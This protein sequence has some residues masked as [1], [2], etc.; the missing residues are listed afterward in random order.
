MRHLSLILASCLLALAF[1]GPSEAKK[2]KKQPIDPAQYVGQSTTDAMA[3]LVA[4]AR[5]SVKEDTWETIAIARVLLLGGQEAEGTK[6]LDAVADKGDASDLVRVGRVYQ[7]A[8]DWPAAKK[9][10]DR[11]VELEPKD[12]DWLAE[13]G[14]YYN[15]AGDRERAEELFG[16]SFEIEP[17]NWRNMLKAAGSYTGVR[18]D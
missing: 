8:G 9:A 4:G 15:L 7:E 10:F 16:R 12:A 2:K 17:T 18:P 14:G 13:I 3:A 5:A 11:V 6:M 1:A